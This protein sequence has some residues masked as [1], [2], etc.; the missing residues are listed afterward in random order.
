M[1][2]GPQIT[3]LQMQLNWLR[4]S[5][6]ARSTAFDNLHKKD[7]EGIIQMF[8]E[9]LRTL[10]RDVNRLLEDLIGYQECRDSVDNK[11]RK[12]LRQLETLDAAQH[13]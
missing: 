11:F 9:E 13:A 2:L 3:V 7:W 5:H 12:V 6:G 10:R 8:T 4:S 1:D